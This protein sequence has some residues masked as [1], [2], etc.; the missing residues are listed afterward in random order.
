M[1]GR[2]RLELPMVEIAGH[3][4]NGEGT[5]ALARAFGVSQMTVW[6]RL[7][8][9]GVKMRPWTGRPGEKPRLGKYK[10]GGPLSTDGN[11]YLS[12]SARDRKQCYVHRGC[13]EAHHG[14]ILDGYVVHHINGDKAD[15]RESNLQVQAITKSPLI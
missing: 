2:A 7:R 14:S 15:N 4:K 10:R 11:G 13:W 9:M 8:A 6:R 5:H 12:T 3:Y 1:N